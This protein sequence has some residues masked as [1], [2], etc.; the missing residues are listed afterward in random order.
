MDDDESV[1]EA[2]KSLLTSVGFR[3]E[4]F[5]IFNRTTFNDISQ[6]L[7]DRLPTDVAFTSFTEFLKTGSTFGQFIRSRSPREIQIGLKVNF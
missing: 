1:G 6:T 4:V 3:V 5:N 2:L 7:P